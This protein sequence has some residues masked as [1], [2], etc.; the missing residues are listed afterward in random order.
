LAY[1][2]K[3]SLAFKVGA[4]Q[5]ADPYLTS[6]MISGPDPLDPVRGS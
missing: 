4:T 2:L 5:R 6:G 3:R 1:K